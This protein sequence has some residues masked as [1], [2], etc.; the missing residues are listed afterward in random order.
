MLHSP[1]RAI[2][3]LWQRPAVGLQRTTWRSGVG[4]QSVSRWVADPFRNCHSYTPTYLAIHGL[5]PQGRGQE[6]H[7]A[8]ACSPTQR[9]RTHVSTWGGR[10]RVPAGHAPLS[11]ASAPLS[12][13]TRILISVYS[14]GPTPSPEARSWSAHGCEPSVRARWHSLGAS[15]CYNSA[16]GAVAVAHLPIQRREH[17]IPLVL[18]NLALHSMHL[19]GSQSSRGGGAPPATLR[20]RACTASKTATG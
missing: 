20:A 11:A 4:S 9:G 16:L 10:R 12:S 17:G 8:L 6:K 2:L 19:R 15:C 13:R 7:V 3:S 5:G 14:W 18:D 1:V